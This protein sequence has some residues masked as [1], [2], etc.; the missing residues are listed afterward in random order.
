[1]ARGCVALCGQR[2]LG[3]KDGKKPAVEIALHARQVEL[4]DLG[5]HVVALAEIPAG[6]AE[7]NGG[8]EVTVELENAPV[9]QVG[10]RGWQD[11]PGTTGADK[12]GGQQRDAGQSISG[13]AHWG[14]FTGMN[15]R[16]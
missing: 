10:R 14:R 13:A 9:R 3:N 11:R 7:V 15:W 2:A 4:G 5:G 16:S 1:M 6:A 8:I 12:R